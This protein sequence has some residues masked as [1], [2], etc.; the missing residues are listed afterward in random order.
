M[1]DKSQLRARIGSQL[2]IELLDASGSSEKMD[3]TIVPDRAADFSR[4]LLGESTPLGK[5]LLD[6]PVGATLAYSVGDLRAVRIISISSIKEDI[7]ESS[8]ERRQQEAEKTRRDIA[9]QNAANFAA[10]FS[11][12]WGDYDPDGMMNWDNNSKDKPDNEK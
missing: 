10:S 5:T 12:K 11:G 4:G 8:A 6:Q 9:R 7:I 3:V 1:E 2:T